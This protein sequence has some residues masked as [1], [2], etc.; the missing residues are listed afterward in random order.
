MLDHIEMKPEG[1]M[2]QATAEWKTADFKALAIIARMLSPVFQSMIRNAPS[3]A[4]AW[5]ILREFH[6]KRSLH[7]RVQL[8]QQLHEFVM[9]SGYNIME[10]FLKFDD[11]CT[12]LASV[13]D[14]ISKDENSVVMLGSLPPEYDAIVWNIEAREHVDLC[15]AKEML[16]R[17]CDTMIKR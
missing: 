6:V 11:L 16:R 17:E 3:T 4:H 1:M 2:E 12:R 15:E 7:N 10:H 5:K 8:Y 13:G 14:E 9:T